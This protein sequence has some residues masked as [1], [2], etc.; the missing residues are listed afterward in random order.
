MVDFYISPGT[1]SKYTPTSDY[2]NISMDFNAAPSGTARGT[3]VIIPDDASPEVRAAAEL[4]NI[5]VADF[6]RKYGIEDYPVRGVKTRSE[7]K[8]GVP[9]TV[10]VE[11][12]FNSDLE[13]QRLI[14][15]NPEEFAE[16]YR[17]SFGGLP[18]ARLISPHGEGADRGATSEIFGDE[19]SYG[20]LMANTLLGGEF[21]LAST[22]SQVTPEARRAQYGLGDRDPGTTAQVLQAVAAGDMTKSEAARFVSEDLLEG[23][24]GGSAFDMLNKEEPE[25]EASFLDRLGD[26][27]ADMDFAGVGKAPSMPSRLTR[28]SG[29]REGDSQAGTRALQR[30]GLESLVRPLV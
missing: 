25:E 28:G 30:F 17:M 10:H 26:A 14:Q 16:I 18:N 11:P 23:L 1:R 29:V 2:L 5:M 13:I 20:E 4:Y 7:N 9:N 6:A 19:T 3:E 22:I 21:D 8:R 15:E 12:F 24:T 27:A